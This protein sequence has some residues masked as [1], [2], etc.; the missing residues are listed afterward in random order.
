MQISLTVERRMNVKLVKEL[1]QSMQ[2]WCLW[3]LYLPCYASVLGFSWFVE[4]DGLQ[5]CFQNVKCDRLVIWAS[6]FQPLSQW[7]DT[8]FL[9]WCCFI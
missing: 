6:D 5:V 8:W 3:V 1:T 7:F 4:K 9:S 2:Q